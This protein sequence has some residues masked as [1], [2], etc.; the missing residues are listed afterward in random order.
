MNVLDATFHKATEIPNHKKEDGYSESVLID[1]DGWRKNFAI[2]WYDLD[3]NKWINQDIHSQSELDQK[4][5]KWQ[6]LPF[7]K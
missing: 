5:L 6:Y 3:M 2:G 7:Q 4:N 1:V